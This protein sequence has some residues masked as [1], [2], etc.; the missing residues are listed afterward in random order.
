[1]TI[2]E[3][4]KRT[5]IQRSTIHHYIRCGLLHEPYRT[6][7][8]M[9][10]YDESHI[11][12]L[13][14]ISQIKEEFLKNANTS[15]VPIDFIKAR[16]EET[17]QEP[18]PILNERVKPE[19][20]VTQKQARKKNSIIQAAL[21]LYAEKGYYR[22]NLRDITKKVGISTPAFYHYFPDKRELFIEVIEYVIGEWKT[23]LKSALENETDSSKRAVLMFKIFQEHYPKVGEV[24]NHLRAGV[25]TGDEWAK[26]KLKHVYQ[27]LMVDFKEMT[28]Q[29][30]Q[31]G[32]IRDAD[33]ELLSYFFF[34]IDEAAVQR[35]A[36]DDKYSIEELMAFVGDLISFGFLTDLGRDR[37]LKYREKKAGKN[38]KEQGQP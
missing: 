36:L 18:E 26:T 17:Y 21:S 25:A 1:M 35:L 23:N 5:G 9:A 4:E 12:K 27:V 34:R 13:Q 32:I 10:Y 30:I 31:K 16:L 7:Q 20:K 6:S 19:T 33:V 8:T 22:T 11:T 2:A 24:I 29:S 28:K 37:L 3:L 38:P 15:R 14:M